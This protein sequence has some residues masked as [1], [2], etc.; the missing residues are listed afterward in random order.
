MT[1]P[2][3]EAS[4]FTA[5]GEAEV[6]DIVEGLVRDGRRQEARGVAHRALDGS[7]D[8]DTG[9]AAAA[10]V[11][12]AEGFDALAAACLGKVDDPALR[13]RL[14]PQALAL[15]CRQPA[16]AAGHSASVA[17]LPVDGLTAEE[18]ES[19]LVLALE[20]CRHD[21]VGR[22][23]SALADR[24]TATGRS[25]DLVA[26]S[27]LMLAAALSRSLGRLFPVGSPAKLRG[28][29]TG[30]VTVLVL[31]PF[32]YRG[33]DSDVTD[34]QILAEHQIE[35]A[36]AMLD[37]RTHATKQRSPWR[38][39]RVR[40]AVST[41]GTVYVCAADG[42]T[43]L[44]A[45]VRQ[46]GCLIPQGQ[47]TAGSASHW[48]S[49]LA[50]CADVVILGIRAHDPEALSDRMVAELRRFMPIGVEDDT[51]ALL[52]REFGIDAL[53]TGAW[54]GTPTKVSSRL[55]IWHDAPVVDVSWAAWVHEAGEASA[56]GPP[57][58]AGVRRCWMR[59]AGAVRDRMGA[60][61]PPWSPNLNDAWRG[62]LP[63]IRAA[64]Q[65]LSGPDE[66]NPIE[67]ALAVD[68]N[69]A[70]ALPVV[71]ESCLAHATRPMRFHVLT[72]DLDSSTTN[73]WGRLFSGR[74]QIATYPCDAAR[75]GDSIRLLGHTTVSTL[76]RLLLP[77]LLNT[78][79]RVI[80][81]DVDL[82]VL[83]DLAPLWDADL[84]GHALA[85]KPSS[86]PG[87]R[88]GIQ[89]LYHALGV[90]PLT[91]S[92]PIR[93]WLHETGAMAF[94][95]FNAGVL[96]MDLDKMRCDN[97]VPFLLSLVE[98]CA[99]NDQ[100]ALNTYTRGNYL[101]LGPEWNAAPRQDLTE[102]AKIIHFVGPVK[103]WHDL[104]ISRKCEFE[105]VRDHVE[106]R[107]RELGLD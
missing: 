85:A 68:A 4:P 46:G 97:A 78:V 21:A 63:P 57:G 65:T 103:P 62:W 23:R 79:Q 43:S 50:A 36:R 37:A 13:T 35:F 91:H 26:R 94:R 76:D 12:C 2:S 38:R 6:L 19:C 95:A 88:W 99:M 1:A 30:D 71:V 73:M 9:L 25:S 24:P 31:P 92:R 27:N 82:V 83:D 47:L 22:I 45:S 52:L 20:S 101:P 80:Y 104:Y 74:A 102:G 64:R 39:W 90:Q 44:P 75:Y 89:M 70:H 59:A 60:A 55:A 15:D 49:V 34:D 93:R 40:G 29:A 41:P 100:D 69:L 54:V 96:V 51:S 107:K 48:Q 17:A 42:D 11:A 7:A 56:G 33:A 5:N 81:L 3:N 77:E 61:D 84:R 87:T 86:S 16:H 67:V 14:A 18:L 66:P 8:R 32:A 10:V 28:P 106:Q 98:Q 58:P 53:V 105:S 72:H